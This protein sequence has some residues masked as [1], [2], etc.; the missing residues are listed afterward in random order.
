MEI[1]ILEEDDAH[2]HPALLRFKNSNMSGKIGG[3]K[4]SITMECY[5]VFEFEGIFDHIGK[6]FLRDLEQLPVFSI[7]NIFPG[8]QDKDQRETLM[9]II[10]D[11]IIDIPKNRIGHRGRFKE[12]ML[13]GM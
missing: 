6:F 11:I 2:G 12:V 5:L 4:L 7:R 13:I 1:E 9:R 3:M 8:L 10:D